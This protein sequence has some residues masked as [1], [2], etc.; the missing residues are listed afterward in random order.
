MNPKPVQK[1]SFR[2]AFLWWLKLGFFFAGALA[3]RML[4]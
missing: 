4:F 1:P 2:E 3:W